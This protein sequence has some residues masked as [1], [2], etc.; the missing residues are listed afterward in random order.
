[1]FRWQQSYLKLVLAFV[2]LEKCHYITGQVP[3]GLEKRW[4]ALPGPWSCGGRNVHVEWASLPGS[5]GRD[6]ARAPHS[7]LLQTAS[8]L[9]ALSFR[10]PLAHLITLCC[11]FCEGRLPL[12]P[13]TKS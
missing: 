10:P 8:S 6:G 13:W 5:S 4:P 9:P 2:V 7:L 3:A 12:E 11:P 1:M